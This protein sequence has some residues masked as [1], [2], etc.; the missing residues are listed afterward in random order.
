MLKSFFDTIDIAQVCSAL[1]A[2][3]L[4]SASIALVMKLHLLPQIR[5]MHDGES[6]DIEAG[7]NETVI[8]GS[9]PS[10]KVGE[11]LA[12]KKDKLLQATHVRLDLSI[13]RTLTTLKVTDKSK[14]KTFVNRHEVKSTKAFINDTIKIGD[15][16]FK[17]QA[18]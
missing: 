7:V 17:V 5:S 9:K 12:L 8:I 1:Q 10:S 4:D 16:S 6:Y 3:G 11:I 2:R 14:G 15:T 18:L 13:N